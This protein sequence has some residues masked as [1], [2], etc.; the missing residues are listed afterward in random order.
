MGNKITIEQIDFI[1]VA[2]GF[3]DGRAIVAATTLTPPAGSNAT[4]IMLQALTQNV[5]YTLDGTVPEA[6]KGFQLKAG[7][8]PIIIPY[9]DG[10]TTLKVIEEAATADLQEQWG[11]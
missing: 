4:K 3:S 10:K 2:S 11:K 7:D 1:P 6:A 8:P 9:Y 5:R